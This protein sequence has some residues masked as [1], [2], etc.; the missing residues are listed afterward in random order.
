VKLASCLAMSY[1]PAHPVG[2][3]DESL[4]KLRILLAM[5]LFT[6]LRLTNDACSSIA[7]GSG[8]I[9]I[10]TER[11]AITSLYHFDNNI[12]QYTKWIPERVKVRFRDSRRIL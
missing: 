9:V 10:V 1:P 7:K 6:I 12:C 11:S 2:L 8:K 4:K 5:H 3:R